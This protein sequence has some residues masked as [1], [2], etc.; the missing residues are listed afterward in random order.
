[1]RMCTCVSAP[2]SLS[3]FCALVTTPSPILE[4]GSGLSVSACVL[5]CTAHLQ[6]EPATEFATEPATEFATEFAHARA[7]MHSS[8][9]RALRT[10]NASAL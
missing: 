3:A 4:R 6:T 8:T 10:G 7:R 1:M 2:V 5:E 9:P